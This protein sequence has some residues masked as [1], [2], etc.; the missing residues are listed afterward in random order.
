[1]LNIIFVSDDISADLG[2]NCKLSYDHL[3]RE[4]NLEGNNIILLNGDLC[5][6]E[7][8]GKAIASFQE[9]RFILVAFSHGCKEAL[10]ST[11]AENGYVSNENSYLFST[12]L[13]Y[14][15]CCYSGVTL[16]ENLIDAGCFGYVGYTDTVRLPQ[17]EDDDILFIACENRGLIHFLTTTESLAASI[18]HMKTN[19][20]EQYKAFVD[21]DMNVAAAFLL[22]NLNCLTFHDEV[23]LTRQMLEN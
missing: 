15:N 17:N 14:T 21:Q 19:Y 1:M 10:L 9:G 4:V 5:T 3:I 20:L 8:V 11:A 13:V 12:S 6:S 22:H 2:D 16:K 23:D 7:E 18:T